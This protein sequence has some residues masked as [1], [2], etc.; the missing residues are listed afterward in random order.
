MK[1]RRT[2]LPLLALLLLSLPGCASS[3]SFSRAADPILSQPVSDIA[4]PRN[5][6]QA[7]EDSSSDTTYLLFVLGAQETGPTAL[8]RAAS[9]ELEGEFSFPF[10]ATGGFLPAAALF[11][12]DGGASGLLQ[13]VPLDSGTGVNVH[14][15][16]VIVPDEG[17]AA[18]AA[19][20]LPGSL[21]EDL[22]AALT[23]RSSGDA[24]T[25]SIAGQTLS[26]PSGG[27]LPSGAGVTL[28]T[29]GDLLT[30]D[31]SGAAPVLSLGLAVS[32]GDAHHISAAR[33]SARISFQGGAFTL[34]DLSLHS[35]D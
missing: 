31:L 1:F 27:A 20:A 5:P 25:F 4:L 24:L 12:L 13:D 21:I 33:L 15:L 29:P 16:F 3:P 34:S 32:A 22:A 30:F 19:Y 28:D 6:I 10:P 11:E 18:F 8:L 26:V 17:S 14:S 7:I 9:G 23:F 2:L 35:L